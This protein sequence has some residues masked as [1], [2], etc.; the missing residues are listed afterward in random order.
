[1]SSEEIDV[2]VRTKD[3]VST[4][5]DCL[6][7]IQRYVPVRHIIIVD[8]GSTDGTLEV[9][10]THLVYPKVILCVEPGLSLG[11]A[12][13]YGVSKAETE[14]V[15][16]ID[17]DVM[18]HP[19]WYR[20]L[21]KRFSEDV[22]VVE[23]GNIEHYSISCPWN[24]EKN[25]GFLINLIGRREV[26]QQVPERVLHVREDGYLK[27]YIETE[28]GLHW[29]KSGVCVADHY[30]DAVRYRNTGSYLVVHR[31]RVPREIMVQS[32]QADKLIGDKRLVRL[33]L[34][35]FSVPL[36]LCVDMIRSWC[37]YLYGWYRKD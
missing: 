13:S 1:M 23:G 5:G 8:G 26:F 33:F 28:I 19:G 24:G 29:I 12:F 6:D 7:A 37:W 4:I 31:Y 30:S 32:A 34:S 11:E 2:I 17:S 20:E 9:I 25:R 3:C 35:C 10:R 18:V 16:N 27:H 14:F 36:L 21:S 15:A 22:A